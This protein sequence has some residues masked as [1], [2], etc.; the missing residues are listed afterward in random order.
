MTAKLKIKVKETRL[1]LTEGE[2]IKGRGGVGG[3]YDRDRR[4]DKQRAKDRKDAD[5]NQVHGINDT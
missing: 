3:V 5:E 4:I 2:G 1:T